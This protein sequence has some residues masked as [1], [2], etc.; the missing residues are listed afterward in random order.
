MPPTIDEQHEDR[1]EVE[2]DEPPLPVRLHG[3][4]AE[5]TEAG[6]EELHR[7]S[8][9]KQPSK[10]EVELARYIH[11]AP[12]RSAGRC[13]NLVA[14]RGM[15]G[16]GR[17]MPRGAHFVPNR[18]RPPDGDAPSHA[19]IGSESVGMVDRSG[20]LPSRRERPHLPGARGRG[21]V[22]DVRDVGPDL[23]AVR[24]APDVREV[25][26][27]SPRIVAARSLL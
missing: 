15:I 12:D 3:F 2:D 16:I 6:E 10:P 24:L 11:R 18:L 4:A 9:H 22:A 20:R 14:L 27:A 19:R 26:P 8:E 1:Y 7:D 25:T 5:D 21:T 23:Q 17:S 13:R